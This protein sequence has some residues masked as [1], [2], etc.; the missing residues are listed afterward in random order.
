ML[1]SCSKRARARL[2]D[3][4]RSYLLRGFRVRTYER[5]SVVCRRALQCQ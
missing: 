3:R 1:R 5:R 2:D 4:L